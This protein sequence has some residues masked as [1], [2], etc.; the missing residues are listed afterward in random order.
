VPAPPIDFDLISWLNHPGNALLDPVM[1]SASSAR[2]LI[3]LACALGLYILFRSP[4]KRTG[5]LV[6]CLAIGLSDITAARILKPWAQRIRPCNLTTPATQTLAECQKGLS[7]PSNHAA[8]AA[9]AAGVA[10]WAAPVIAPYCIA[11]ALLVGLSRVYLGQHWPTD[12][13][14]G[15]ALGALIAFLCIQ[16]ARLRYALHRRPTPQGR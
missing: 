12:V 15:W 8:N 4:Q 6:L 7:F 16:T 2:L 14:A 13:L 3:P 10:S 9:A 1:S 5:V 11:L